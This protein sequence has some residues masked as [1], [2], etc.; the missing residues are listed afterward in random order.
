MPKY[1]LELKDKLIIKPHPDSQLLNGYIPA[2]SQENLQDLWSYR[3]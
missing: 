3:D 2:S 1:Q